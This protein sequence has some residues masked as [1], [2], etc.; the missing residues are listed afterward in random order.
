M[1]FG[2]IDNLFRVFTGEPDNQGRWSD[3]DVATLVNEAQNFI[4]LT[5]QWPIVHFSAST[6]ASQ[7]EY[8]LPELL[9]IERVY[10]AGQPC[11]PT[12]IATLEGTQIE[13]YDQTNPTTT[14]TP[15]WN[16]QPAT[17]YPVVNTQMGYPNGVSPYYVGERPQYYVNGGNIGFVPPPIA[18]Y[19]MDL[20]GV[21]VPQVLANQND[22]CD[23]PSFFKSAIAHKAAELALL[24]DSKPQAAQTQGLKFAEWLPKLLTWR[25]TL[26]KNK[27]RGPRV[28]AYRHFYRRGSILGARYGR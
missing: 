15:N 18:A 10:L 20:W 13:F 9:Q 5:I 28:I 8:T 22:A 19:T 6:V 3:T 25:Q 23:F 7:Q 14:Y 12:D 16:N 27:S 11:V 1:T 17:A 26:V 4:A 21:G 24:S 2:D